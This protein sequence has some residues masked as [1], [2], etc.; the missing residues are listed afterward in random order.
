LDDRAAPYYPRH[1][2]L[3][4]AERNLVDRLLDDVR[5]ERVQHSAAEKA[6]FEALMKQPLKSS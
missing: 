3:S 5:A 2:T 1:Q 6:Q 4:L